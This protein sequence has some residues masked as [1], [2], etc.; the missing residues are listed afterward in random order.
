MRG[1]ALSVDLGS[2]QLCKLA[3]ITS[4]QQPELN[5]AENN[6]KGGDGNGV[7]HQAPDPD[8]VT[9]ASKHAKDKQN[10]WLDRREILTIEV[11]II[12]SR[13]ARSLDLLG[14][15]RTLPDPRTAEAACPGPS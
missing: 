8:C 3:S 15:S 14:A 10:P 4:V 6:R 5:R 9:E 11:T 1:S 13:R 2:S 12:L 7:K